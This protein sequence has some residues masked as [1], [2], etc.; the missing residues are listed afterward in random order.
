VI[1]P[2][3]NSWRLAAKIS[4][5]L[6]LLPLAGCA[7]R[8]AAPDQEQLLRPVPVTAP[9]LEHRLAPSFFLEGTQNL[10]NRVGGVEA[11]GRRGR[12]TVTV[13]PDRPV[14]YTG[15]RPFVTDRGRYTNLIY[16]IHFPST[17]FSLV[18]FRLG[19]GDHIG[20]LVILTLDADQRPL[21]VTTANTCGCYAITIPT[22]LLP[23]S[24][25]PDRWPTGP[26]AVYGE[27]LPATLPALT[28]GATLQ[29]GVRAEVHR[30]KDLQILPREG[31]T[32]APV[33]PAE[34]APLDSL[35]A[36]PLDDG[37]FT[38]FYYER[39]PLTGHVKGAIK[40]WETLLLSLV[41]LDLFV[42]M[43]KVYDGVDTGANPFYTSLKPWNR[44]ASDMNDFAAY[45]HFNGWK[46]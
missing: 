5:L 34:M 43:D 42:G 44:S 28:A 25:Y 35:A 10:H 22:A 19:A 30:V 12:A 29:V 26:L 38:S 23:A 39:W 31:V 13:N 40:P 9:S 7:G 27:Q 3:Q 14:L 45:L 2:P 6:C 21:L 20:L 37:T 18:P 15:H 32:A 8:S 11:S 16:R 46:L 17:P 24:A 36:L 33:Q 1:C 41:S 4:L